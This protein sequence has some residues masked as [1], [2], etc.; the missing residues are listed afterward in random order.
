[1]RY[2]DGHGGFYEL[3][4]FPGCNQLVVSNHS[5][6]CPS[7]RGKGLGT[8]IHRQRLEKA[9]ILGYDYV[10]C[11]VKADNVPQINLLNHNGWKCLDEFHNRETGNDVMI[12][13]RRLQENEE[14]TE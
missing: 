9:K 4:P 12:F 3:N 11:T 7:K 10:L 6:I 8:V 5:W 14:I 2:E 1:M 13:G